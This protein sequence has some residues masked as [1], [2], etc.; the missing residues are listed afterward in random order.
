MKLKR[1]KSL[2]KNI[3]INIAII[4]LWINTLLYVIYAAFSIGSSE[5]YIGI[6]ALIVIT[7]LPFII[8]VHYILELLES[9][10]N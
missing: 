5:N 3:I 4:A 8:L 10:K 9:Y 2:I 7:F 6:K 1:F